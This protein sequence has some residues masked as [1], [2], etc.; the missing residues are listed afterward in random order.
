MRTLYLIR[1]G[2]P[3]QL[4]GSRRCISR[5][6][7][8]LDDVGRKQAAALREWLAGRGVTAVYTSPAAR[9]VETAQ[10]AGC[11][12]PVHRTQELWEVHVGQWEGLP[13]PEIRQRWPELYAA[14]GVH[15][16]TVAPPGGESFAQAAARMD[17]AVARILA[18]TV[19][20][21]A[22]VSHGGILRAWLCRIQGIEL[23]RLFSLPQPWGGVSTVQ[24]T[25]AGCCVR[26][27]GQV[28]RILRDADE[29]MAISDI[30]YAGRGR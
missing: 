3:A 23:D 28:P 2:Q 18:Q 24:I 1:H 6:D 17:R 10:I 13:F 20:D 4:E 8:P 14:R 12:Q 7:L 29:A 30:V 22:V 21:V 26:T 25:R 11:S 16:G 15:L 9:C 19:G 27:V 5:T